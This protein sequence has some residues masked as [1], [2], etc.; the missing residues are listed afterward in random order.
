MTN[1][2]FTQ[3]ATADAQAICERLDAIH[4]IL[5]QLSENQGPQGLGWD[6]GQTPANPA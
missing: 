4:A 3:P 6:G 5:Q 1:N 2:T